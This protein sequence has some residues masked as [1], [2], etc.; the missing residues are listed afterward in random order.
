MPKIKIAY[1]KAPLKKRDKGPFIYRGQ[2]YASY[3][4]LVKAVGTDKL[5]YVGYRYEDVSEDD[6]RYLEQNKVVLEPVEVIGNRT[7]KPGMVVPT[8]ST[9]DLKQEAITDFDNIV[10]TGGELQGREVPTEFS[11]DG[12]TSFERALSGKRDPRGAK[13]YRANLEAIGM[14]PIFGNTRVQNSHNAWAKNPQFMQGWTNA[15]TLASAT[16]LS[17]YAIPTAVEAAPAVS[18]WL[19]NTG[20]PWV[21]KYIAAPTAAGMTWD[22]T[23]KALTGTTTTEQISNYLQQKGWNPVV[24]EMVGGTSNPGYWINFGGVG[25]YTRPLFNKIGLGLSNPSAPIEL[26]PTIQANINASM[27]KSKF[28]T[29]VVEPVTNFYNTTRNAMI[30]AIIGT[31]MRIMPLGKIQTTQIPLN[32]GWGPRQTI[33][34]THKS[35]QASPLSLYNE[36]R[37]DVLNEGANPLGIWFQGKFGIP[38]ETVRLYRANPRNPT[39]KAAMAENG[40]FQEPYAGMWFTDDPN[41]IGYYASNY[42]RGR[43]PFE[44]VNLQYVDIP[45]TQLEQYRASK[46]L[47]EGFEYEPEDFIIPFNIPRTTI[48]FNPTSKVGTTQYLAEWNNFANS[49]PISSGQ[50]ALRA[51]S[52]FSNRPYTHSGDLTLDKPLVTIGDVPDRSLLSYQAERL[53]ADGLIYNNVYDNGYDANQVILSFKQPD[54]YMLTT[55]AYS[56]YRSITTN[57]TTSVKN[58]NIPSWSLNKLPGY[59][60]KSL[61]SESPLE[62]QLSKNGTLSLKQLQ[63][64]V[65]RNDVSA[66]DK[67][68]LNRVLQNHANDTHIDYNTLRQEVQEMIPQYTQHP[69][70]EYITYGMDRLGFQINKVSDGAG[71][72]V[73]TYSGFKPKTF[74]FESPGIKGNNRHYQGNPI[75]HSRTYTTAEEPDILY[76]M[77]SQSDW[78]QHPKEF[79]ERRNRIN[80]IVNNFKNARLNQNTL[81]YSEDRFN[82]LYTEILDDLFNSN[83]QSRMIDTYPIRQLQE[84]LQYAAKSGLHKMRY[85][86]PE[87]AAKIEGY[88]KSEYT[89]E[90]R[91]LVT[92]LESITADESKLRALP[93][94]IDLNTNTEVYYTPKQREQLIQDLNNRIADLKLAQKDRTYPPEHLTILKKY[95]DFPKQFQKLFGK[96]AEVKTVTDAK[97]NTWYEVDVPEN[98][99]NGTAEMLFRK[100]GK[101][102]SIERFKRNRKYK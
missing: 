39:F 30:P 99:L 81:G 100:G 29:K 71:G 1:D 4:D 2:Q 58:K 7:S 8:A 92:Q 51:R 34:V 17:P 27:P 9:E 12:K 41:K 19:M 69:E 62:K 32:V 42:V 94:E 23:Q 28:Q 40:I 16:L 57:R 76:V 46:V 3:D 64:Y 74:T 97:G 63:A 24:S 50:K 11:S 47:P 60:I 26:S 44:G 68:M 85:P 25:K 73:D 86:T 10:F 31:R 54:N 80:E 96:K 90:Y 95:A 88:V 6:P 37:W 33:S 48:P 87:T 66:I 65:N 45:K 36:Q 75:G 91:D 70:S 77:E 22:L 61:M 72:L 20:M 35:G 56:P 18:N 78:A 83:I 43:D 102:N 55:N 89:P 52:L 53:G 21:A 98:Y 59:Q 49:L 101:L 79:H 67:E 15:Q 82:E 5:S 13:E 38:R 14:N 93:D 84:N